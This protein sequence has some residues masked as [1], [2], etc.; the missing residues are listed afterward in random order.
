[1]SN[2]DICTLS[3]NLETYSLIWLDSQSNSNEKIKQAQQRVRSSINDLRIFEQVNKCIK[4]IQLSTVDKI[5]VVVNNIE[6]SEMIIP[7]IHQLSQIIAIYIYNINDD[8]Q[9]QFLNKYSKVKFNKHKSFLIK[10]II[11][12]LFDRSKV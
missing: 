4:N 7:Y 5:I 6:L 3:L 8:R 10:I 12:N 9:T 2:I 11:S 1:M